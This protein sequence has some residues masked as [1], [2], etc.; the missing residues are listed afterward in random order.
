MFMDLNLTEYIKPRLHKWSISME[1]GPPRLV[2]ANKQQIQE[3]E[4]IINVSNNNQWNK[5]KLHL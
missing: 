3:E 2:K 4:W 5:P 1:P